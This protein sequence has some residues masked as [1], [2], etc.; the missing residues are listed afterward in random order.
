ML[1]YIKSELYRITHSAMLYVL[2]FAF[3]A[4][5]ALMNIMLYC[6]TLSIPNYQML[7]QVLWSFVLLHYF[8]S[9]P[10]MKEIREMAI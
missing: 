2:G 8:W 7:W 3:A 5:P 10:S 4:M 9:M 1:N 6:F